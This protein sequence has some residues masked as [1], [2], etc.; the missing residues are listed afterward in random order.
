MS[1]HDHMAEWKKGSILI[2]APTNLIAAATAFIP[3][4]W[5]C[6][7][8]HCWPDW[9]VVLT[10]WGMTAASFGAFYSLTSR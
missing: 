8:H 10:A 3:V 1:E 4:L 9:N 7:T 6:S 5:L 2:G